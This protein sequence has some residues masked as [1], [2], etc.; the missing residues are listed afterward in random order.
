MVQ[1]DRLLEDIALRDNNMFF[2]AWG[3]TFEEVYQKINPPPL[4]ELAI[5][6]T[7]GSGCL[8]I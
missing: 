3:F 7:K 8:E 4:W 5:D 2:E 1:V 6:S